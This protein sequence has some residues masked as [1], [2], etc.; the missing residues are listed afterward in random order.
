MKKSIATIFLLAALSYAQDS[1]YLVNTLMGDSVSK[2]IYARG[3][4][5]INGDGYAD[6]VVSFTDSVKIYLGNENFELK[7][8]YTFG[9]NRGFV[10][11]PGDVNNDGF[12][13]L[14]I[15]ERR[16][17]TG[18]QGRISNIY[19]F[20]GGSNSLDTC[21]SFLYSVKYLDQIFSKKVE[22]IGDVNGDGYNDFAIAA[23]YNWTNGI[24]YVFVYL[25]GDSISSEPFVTFTHSPFID[26][27]SEA[28]FG[29][30]IS[31]IGDVN[32][33]GYDDILIGDP[34]Y[35]DT[36]GAVSSGRVCLYYGAADMDSIADSVF[37]AENGKNFGH[38]IKNIGDINGNGKDEFC[39]TSPWYYSSFYEFPNVIFTLTGPESIG[40]GGDIDNDGL[41]DFLANDTQYIND[42]DIMVGASFLHYG[43]SELDTIYDYKLEGEHKWDEYS[44]ISDIIGDFNGDGFDDF[45]VFAPL[46]HPDNTGIIYLYSY[47][48]YLSIEKQN[49][50]TIIN[51]KLF[52]NYPNPFN[53]STVINY[54]VSKPVFVRIEI[55]DINGKLIKTIVNR[56][57]VS[58][59][60]KTIWNGK[61]KQ[62]HN[63]ASGVYF[64]RFKAGDMV[65]NKKMLLLR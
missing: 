43:S 14:L 57:H 31:G 45:F 39:I 50:Q 56:K 44:K 42:N 52:Q 28:T 48:E 54:Q 8:D 15:G 26:Q 9:N 49:N 16:Y 17:S 12:D 30:T 10:L 13:D 58:G 40:A 33:D 25:G 21:K 51:F 22:P 55:Y 64:Y 65:L 19:L 2:I 47:K 32:N 41:N 37:V 61:N 6:F 46:K 1:L 27:N 36:I 35:A 59:K 7:A 63:V 3:A 18:F 60:Y 4:G 53:P 62:G 29:E 23:T 11:C 34:G 20:F 5:D 24:S 38:I